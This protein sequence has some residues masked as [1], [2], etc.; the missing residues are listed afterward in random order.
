MTSQ[1]LGIATR[2]P[3]SRDRL[4]RAGG[5]E[6]LQR[7]DPSGR[8]HDAAPGMRGGA[9]HPEVLDRRPIARPSGNRAVEEELLERELALEDVALRQAEVALDVERRQHLLVE[10]DVADVRRALLD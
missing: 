5:A 2:L 6:Y 10:D 4:L 9:A 1:R 7:R 8:P 3:S